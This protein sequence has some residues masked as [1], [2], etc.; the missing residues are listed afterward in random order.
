MTFDPL[1]FSLSPPKP[2]LHPSQR[3]RTPGAFLVLADPAIYPG[4]E[5]GFR[6]GSV[7]RVPP[8]PC[9]LSVRCLPVALKGVLPPQTILGLVISSEGCA[10]TSASLVCSC[11]F[12]PSRSSRLVYS[13]IVGGSSRLVGA[14]LENVAIAFP[15]FVPCTST[16]LCPQA[17]G[18]G[19]SSSL[20][21]KSYFICPLLCCATR[22]FPSFISSFTDCTKRKQ[23]GYIIHSLI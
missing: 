2:G 3:L 9:I 13:S 20:P 17:S 11:N 23:Q 18:L 1:Y 19:T 5:S 21:L 15:E 7:S 22:F 6:V 8:A 14:D 12:G 4:P 16:Q 10:R